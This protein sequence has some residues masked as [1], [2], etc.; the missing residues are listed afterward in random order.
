[1]R[2]ERITDAELRRVFA[3]GYATHSLPN[4]QLFDFEGLRGRV[5]SSSY[6]PGAGQSGHDQMMAD[7]RLLFDRT[8]ENGVVSFDY[9]TQIYLGRVRRS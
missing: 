7:L 5:L 9:E 1:V 2:H 6:A 3:A 8:A 4:R